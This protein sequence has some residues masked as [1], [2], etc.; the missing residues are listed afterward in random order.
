MPKRL[1]LQGTTLGIPAVWSPTMLLAIASL[2]LIA[3][4]PWQVVGAGQIPEVNGVLGGVPSS[5]ANGTATTRILITDPITSGVTTTLPPD[6]TTE[7][8]Y[9]TTT[10]DPVTETDT[11][12]DTTTTLTTTMASA[13]L[14]SAITGAAAPPVGVVRIIENSGICGRAFFLHSHY[15]ISDKSVETTRGVYQASGYI[16]LSPIEHMWYVTKGQIL[17]ITKNLIC[18]GSGFSALVKIQKTRHL[19]FGSMGV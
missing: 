18:I 19:F 6:T 12:D 13:T 5:P 3:S 8:T 2:A 16:D 10:L 15:L 4:L 1:V 7:P 17:K 14:T 9:T 11:A